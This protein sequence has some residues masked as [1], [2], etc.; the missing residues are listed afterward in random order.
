[1]EIASEVEV[2]FLHWQY[3][4]IAT[5]GSTAFHAK[6]WAERGLT[7]GEDGTFANLCHA[8]GKTDGYRCLAIT[9]LG[10]CHG[11]HKYEF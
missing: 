10:R 11:C 7:Q 8:K 3:L 6:T 4:R 2:D 5:T 9:T 1:M